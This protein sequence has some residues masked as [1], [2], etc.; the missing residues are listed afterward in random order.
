[1]MRLANKTI[2]CCAEWHGR[3]RVNVSSDQGRTWSAPVTAASWPYG[4]AANPE[5]MQLPDKTLLL[6]C[7][8]RPNDHVHDF[9]IAIATSSDNGQTWSG[10]KTVYEAGTDGAHGCWEPAALVGADKR[11]LHLFFSLEAP[12]GRVGDQAIVMMRSAN[13]GVSWSEPERVSYRLGHRD[14]MP[15]PLHLA[16]GMEAFSIEDNG[17]QP[18]LLFR[19]TI[20]CTSANA[21]WKQPCA[22]PGSRNRWPALADPLPY[23]KTAAAPYLRQFPSGETVLSCQSDAFSDHL[24]QVVFV[25]DAYARG[26]KEPSVPFAGLSTSP[27]Q[28]NSLFIKNANTVTAISG[29]TIYGRYGVWAVDGVL[30]GKP[31]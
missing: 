15:V 18:N 3:S 6:F 29:T 20:V 13:N 16:A 9:G 14:G 8:L 21:D 17:M 5:V 4:A 2:L 23:G 27:G 11:E 25:G 22:M 28:W 10:L 26:F 19:P 7:N 30:A 31:K 24:Q 12:D 1:M